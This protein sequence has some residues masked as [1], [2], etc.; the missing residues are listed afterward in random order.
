MSKKRGL[1]LFLSFLIFASLSKSTFAQVQEST[2]AEVSVSI[3]DYEF[4]LFGYGVPSSLVTLE[5]I[6]IFDQTYSDTKGYFEFKNRFSPFSTREPCLYSQDQLGRVSQTICIPSFPRNRNVSIGPV[7]LPPTVHLN[8]GEYFTGDQVILSGQTVPNTDV[9]LSFFIDQTRKSLF[10]FVK[11]ANAVTFPKLTVKSD[12]KGNYS[13]SLPSGQ[14]DYYRVF[15]QDVFLKQ[16]SPRSTTLSVEILPWWMIIMQFFLLMW[17]L[18]RSRFLEIFILVQ[19]L[20]L[21][22]YFL[23]AYLKPH[24]IAKNK[25][26]ALRDDRSLLATEHELTIA[27]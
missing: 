21:L 7:L 20:T 5:G 15:A 12:T 2:S 27:D 3:G 4:R 11:P 22:Y 17:D 25:A 1:A 10:S 18:I 13:I 9:D 16:D 8:K 26:L 14:A 23:R 19:I 6:G 24:I